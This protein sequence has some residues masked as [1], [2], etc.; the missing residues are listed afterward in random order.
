MINLTHKN[1]LIVIAG[2]T[3]IGKTALAIDVAMHFNTEIVSADSRQFYKELKIGAAFPNRK[4]LSAVKHHFIGNLSIT[5]EYNVSKYEQDALQTLETIFTTQTTAVLVGGSGLYLDAVCKGIDE[6]PDPDPEL[7]ESIKT[8]FYEN[9]ITALQSK[10]KLLDPEY[11]NQVDR[12]NPKR[13]MRA[14]E[15]CITTGKTYTSLRLSNPKP[16]DFNIIKIGL[17]TDREVMYWRINQRT[18]KMIKDGLID[19]AF[20]LLSFRNYNALNTVGYKELFNYFD[21][22]LTLEEAI[23]K[24]KI[25]TRR[26]AKRQLTW[27]NKDKNIIWIDINNIKNIYDVLNF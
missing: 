27:F 14:I 4:E 11:Y 13:L 3:G 10:L 8:L 24:I 26:Y 2:P 7:R 19:E 6:L 22:T 25:N 16:R 12:D 18:D 5:D 23:D 17:F 1:T 15:V 9:G 21:K 20:S